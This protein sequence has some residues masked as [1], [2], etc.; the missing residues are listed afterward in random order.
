M[1]QPPIL[2]RTAPRQPPGHSPRDNLQSGPERR[3]LEAGAGK[4]CGH[5]RETRGGVVELFWVGHGG[6]AQARGAAAPAPPRLSGRTGLL[7]KDEVGACVAATGERGP[8]RAWGAA[9]RIPLPPAGLKS[10][11][12]PAR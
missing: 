9:A 3:A 10:A 4:E 8:A 5:R 1:T 11:P 6:R 12:S 7:P 2:S